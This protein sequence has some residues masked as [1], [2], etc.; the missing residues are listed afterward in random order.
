[1]LFLK[2]TPCFF[3]PLDSPLFANIQVVLAKNPLT[4]GYTSAMHAMTPCFG[5][6]PHPKLSTLMRV[7]Q[8]LFRGLGSKL[9]TERNESFPREISIK[10]LT[11]ANTSENSYLFI[12][13]L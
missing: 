2:Y 9:G 13:S 8:G 6:N 10:T 5:S 4:L 3:K 1:M 12:S 7:N 11:T